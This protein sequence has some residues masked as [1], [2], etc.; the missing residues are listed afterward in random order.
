MALPVGYRAPGSA[1]LALPKRCACNVGAVDMRRQSRRS[2]RTGSELRKS[3]T[4]DIRVHGPLTGTSC[5]PTAPTAP[6][7][8]AAAWRSTRSAA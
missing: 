5:D 6:S 8:H 4:D 1:R 7:P 2:T 3:H